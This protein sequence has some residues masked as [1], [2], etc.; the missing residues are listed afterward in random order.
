MPLKEISLFTDFDKRNLEQLLQ[1]ALT[2]TLSEKAEN[3]AINP[4]QSESLNLAKNRNGIEK[5]NLTANDDSLASSSHVENGRKK[6][7][8]YSG[9]AQEVRINLV[10]L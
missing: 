3:N 6:N 7:Q 8:K 9:T 4:Q 1:G 5:A 2:F 10:Y